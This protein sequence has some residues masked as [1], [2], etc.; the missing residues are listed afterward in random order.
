M[1]TKLYIEVEIEHDEECDVSDVLDR[2]L[3]NGDLQDALT[4]YADAAG[5]TIEVTGCYE[6][7]APNPNPP[8]EETAAP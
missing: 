3:D 1:I 8:S 7:N 6:I 5:Y 2:V 4:G